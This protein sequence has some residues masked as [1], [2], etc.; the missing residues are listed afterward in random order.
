MRI[1]DAVSSLRLGLSWRLPVVLQTEA[2][3]CGLACLAMVA[4]YHGKV[5]DLSTL[6]ERCSASI[7]GLSLGSLIEIAERLGLEAQPYRT[8]PENLGSLNLPSILHWNL[9]HFVVL[10]SFGRK[11]VIVDPAVGRRTIKLEELRSS[12][13]GV[14]LDVAP[15]PAFVPVAAARKIDFFRLLGSTVGLGRSLAIVFAFSVGLEAVAITLPLFT[16]AVTDHVLVTG[17]RDLL[18]LLALSFSLIYLT[19]VAVSAARALATTHILAQIGVQWPVGVFAQLLKLPVS[20]FERRELGDVASRVASVSA[21]QRTLT[22]SFVDALIDGIMAVVT[23]TVMFLYSVNLSLVA[24]ASLAAFLSVKVL[25]YGKTRAISQELVVLQARQQSVLLESIRG[26]PTLKMFDGGGRRK[27]LWSSAVVQA[28]NRDIAGQRLSVIGRSLHGVIS[29]AETILVLYLGAIAVL[30]ARMTLGM[31]LAFIS[32]KITFAGRANQLIERIF[33]F[34]LLSVH[35]ERIAD[36]VFAEPEEDAMPGAR[37]P[38]PALLEVRGVGYK[39][40]EMDPWVINGV[41]FQVRKGENVVITGP[42][43]GGKTTL[44]KILCHLVAPTVGEVVWDGVVINAS[45]GAAVRRSIGAVLQSDQLFA[46]SMIE[47]ITFFAESVD[48]EQVEWAAKMA[49]IHDDISRMPMRY[50]SIVGDL[51]SGLSGGQKQRLLLARALYRNPP[52]LIL[53]EATSHLDVVLEQR[54]IANLK[55]LGVTCIQVAHRPET[56]RSADRVLIVDGSGSL[57]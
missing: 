49:E 3:E 11:I 29:S 32:F 45:A 5:M 14:V 30:D 25:L 19:Q 57:R 1:D 4:G 53:D 18:L 7:R 37:F 38:P 16:Q 22:T 39:Y 12:F 20:Y 35:G 13:T 23:L 55:T 56:V 34:R 10:E 26:M 50:E 28:T 8:E 40:S 24:L 54:I 6:R 47:N 51:G 27:R 9:N 15:S 52:L 46:G 48:L 21:L 31:L 36:I 44:A 17:N 2:A 43:G 33:E 41:N 42:S